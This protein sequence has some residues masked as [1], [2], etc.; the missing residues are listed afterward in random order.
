MS[1]I[2][3]DDAPSDV[4]NE[5]TVGLLEN[6]KTAED[7]EIQMGILPDT[8]PA[9]DEVPEGSKDF[10]D[11]ETGNTQ[12]ERI[13]SSSK[14]LSSPY[15]SL[16]LS[17]A[18]IS[19]YNA[20]G[21]GGKFKKKVQQLNSFGIFARKPTNDENTP[22]NVDQASSGSQVNSGNE[23]KLTPDDNKSNNS[24]DTEKDTSNET[25]ADNA[26]TSKSNVKIFNAPSNWSHVKSRLFE[27]DA[28]TQDTLKTSPNTKTKTKMGI[29]EEAAQKTSDEK[30]RN[31]VKIFN[32]SSDYSHVKSRLFAANANPKSSPNMRRKS[33]VGIEDDELSKT[34]G[35]GVKILNVPSNYS[36]VKSKLFDADSGR[37]SSQVS[38][39]DITDA[40][41]KQGNERAQGKEN[42]VSKTSNIKIFNAPSDYS[43]VRSR[44]YDSSNKSKGKTQETSALKT[45]NVNVTEQ[46]THNKKASTDV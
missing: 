29:D 46:D 44:L 3:N 17:G 16:P 26:Q 13:K 1:D 41:N 32:S 31:D 21:G 14:V 30:N 6:N 35:S 19:H 2:S 8:K 11:E 45:N 12:E 20:K 40:Q 38:S 33:K 28:N 43:H 42:Q 27:P 22:K 9:A 25:P 18:Y 36:H 23:E 39:Q 4:S 34:R 7:Q 37:R 15:G 10:K 24:E 5:Q